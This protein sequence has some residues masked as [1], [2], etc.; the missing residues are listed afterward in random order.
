MA[1]VGIYILITFIHSRALIFQNGPLASL[2]GFLDHI[3]TKTRGRTPVDEWSARRRDLYLHRTTQHINTTDK[4]P[5]SER[6]RT[7]DPRNQAAAD[8]RLRPRGHWDRHILINAG[9]KFRNREVPV[10][11][12]GIYRPIS[13]TVAAYTLPTRQCYKQRGKINIGLNISH[14]AEYSLITNCYNSFS[15][16]HGIHRFVYFATCFGISG[17]F[18]FSS[19]FVK[20]T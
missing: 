11:F 2:S 18:H 13:S 12:T 16:E 19:I 6:I 3:H 9:M 17:L 15:I 10:W 20:F 1:A 5:C 7:R 8:L 14:F 4:H